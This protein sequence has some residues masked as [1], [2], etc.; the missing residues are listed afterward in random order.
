VRLNVTTWGAGPRT[1]ALVHGWSDDAQT[2]WRVAPAV[3]ALGFTVLAPDLRGHGLSPRADGYEL[4]DF[5][6]DLVETLPAEPDLLLGHS[7][8]ALACGLAAPSIR[9]RR[10]VLVDPPWQRAT[11]ELGL[12]R[13]LPTTPAEL[14]GHWSAEDTAVDL[15]SNTRLDPRVAHAL[16]AELA[17][18][19][20]LPVPPVVASGSVVLVPELEPV[21]PPSAHEAVRAAGYEI[22]TQPGVRHVMHRDDLDGFLDLL[23]PLLVAEGAVA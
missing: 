13:P 1:A 17:S 22:S 5:A 4:A 2:W 6:A 15:V 8:G 9:P 18:R 16:V 20:P 12:L 21:L 14:P 11:G 10:A 3:A 7:L 19:A 23:R